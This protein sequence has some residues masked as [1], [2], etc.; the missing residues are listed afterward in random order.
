MNILAVEMETSG[1]VHH[2]RA[3]PRQS[4]EPADSLRKQRYG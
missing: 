4:P 3:V 1:A 2:R